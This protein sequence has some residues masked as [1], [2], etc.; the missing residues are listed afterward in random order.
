MGWPRGGTVAGAL[1]RWL[2]ASKARFVDACRSSSTR[3]E[4]KQSAVGEPPG[5]GAYVGDST[6]AG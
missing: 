2:A 3:F 4:E 5:E 6:Y 1:V